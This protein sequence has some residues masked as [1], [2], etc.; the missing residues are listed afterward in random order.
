MM[1]MMMAKRMMLKK[2]M[3]VMVEAAQIDISGYSEFILKMVM[4]SFDKSSDDYDKHAGS[5]ER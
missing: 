3:D 1:M 4:I 5:P 2:N